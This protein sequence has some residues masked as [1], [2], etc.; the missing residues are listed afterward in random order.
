MD[1]E[2]GSF[3]VTD[4]DLVDEGIDISGLRTKTDTSLLGNI[5]ELAGVQY[6]AFNPNRLTDLMRFYQTGLP[7]RSVSP[8]ATGGGGT[9]G[10]S[11][12]T[13]P[14]AINTLVTPSANTL[15]DQRLIDAGIGVQ[16]EPGTVVA[17]GEMPVTQAEMDAFN[18]IPVN[19]EFGAPMDI[20]FGE[21]QVDPKLAAAVGGKDT[22]PVRGGNLVTTA[23][24]DVFAADDPMLQEKIDFTPEQQ[25]TIQNILGQAGQ[26]VG[27][28]LSA[29]GQI[30]GAIVDATNQ[31]VDLFGKKINVG[32]TLAA[33]AINQIAGGPVSLILDALPSGISNTTKVAR[34]TGLLTGDSTVTQDKYGINT[35]SQ[36]GNYDQYNIK[37]VDKLQ[38]RLDELNPDVNPDSKYKTKEDYLK[39]T[40]RLRQE[41]EDRN[42]Y[43]NEKGLKGVGDVDTGRGSGLRPTVDDATGVNPFEDIDTGVG[44]FDTT[45]T[46]APVT[47]VTR[48]GTGTVLGKPGIERFDDAEASID[49]FDDTPPGASTTGTPIDALNPINRQQHFDNTE[50]LKDAVR[51]GD[52]TP[53]EYNRLSAFDATKTMGLGP[54]TGTASAIGY[55]AVQTLAGDQNV[56]DF[57]GDTA[58]NIQGVSGN[59][60][61]EEQVKY[62]EIIT[63]EKIYRDP[64]LGMVEPPAPMTLADDFGDAFSYLDDIDISQ[65][66]PTT[67]VGTFDADTF[68]DD[69]SLDDFDTTPP[70]PPTPTD[71]N[72]INR[73]GGDDIGTGGLDPNRGQ[74]VD[75][76]SSG[77][78][79]NEPVSTPTGPPSTGF[80]PQSTYDAEL[81]DDRDVGGGGN[82]G[83]GNGGGGKIVCTMMNESYGFGSFRNKIWMKFHKDLSPEYQ[84]GYHKLFLPLVKIAKKNIIVKKV[85]EHIAVHST[86]DMRQSM[87][88]KTHLLGRVYRKILLPLCYWV[89]RNG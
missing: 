4:P 27:G 26:T 21:G 13:V 70:A 87:R 23:S 89:G 68:D 15:E 48:P 81:E 33:A 51:A 44:E 43:L 30:P 32:K 75:R 8:P 80:Q 53:E 36:F 37:Q 66:A 49:M 45:P 73:G 65:D 2:F 47:G 11:Q 62:Q 14:G 34:E 60:T 74:Q 22:T 17:P 85:L 69:V 72:I 29:F 10:G 79:D 35:Q 78:G 59:I 82:D 50:K 42:K 6:E 9:G 64:I 31:T 46:T 18:Q 56:S 25:G 39:N 19:R 16:T 24:G 40:K 52:I 55:Q 38:N 61:P 83:G 58:R 1:E 12:A 88:G 77:A 41:L 28:A 71:Q 7:T 57:I 76:G 20:G 86:I 5:P 67:P 63:G 3:V 84:R 54:V